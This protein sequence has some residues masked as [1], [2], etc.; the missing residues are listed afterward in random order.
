M[1]ARYVIISAILA[2]VKRILDWH[3]GTIQV[4]SSLV[5]SGAE[6][7]VTLPKGKYGAKKNAIKVDSVYGTHLIFVDK[8]LSI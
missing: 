7:T 5:L 3:Q 6:F 8:K 4:D 2:I 1:K